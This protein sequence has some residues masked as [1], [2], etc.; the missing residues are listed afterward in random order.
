MSAGWDVNENGCPCKHGSDLVCVFAKDG[1]SA[2]MHQAV[3]LPL[4]AIADDAIFQQEDLRPK[5]AHVILYA[6]RS[7]ALSHF[8]QLRWLRSSYLQIPTEESLSDS[9]K[10]LTKNHHRSHSQHELLTR[11]KLR[12]T[13]LAHSEARL[14]EP[15]KMNVIAL[16]KV[17][18]RY[19]F[20][21]VTTPSF[22]ELELFSEPQ[23]EYKDPP[24]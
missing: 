9:D 10:K 7:W 20:W 14:S 21:I 4:A 18:L 11:C 16:S 15:I 19:Y 5:A 22:S 3:Y 23:G 6:N 17:S 8:E 12:V 24:M 13:G 1:K 2:S